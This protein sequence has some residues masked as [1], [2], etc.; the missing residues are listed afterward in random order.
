MPNVLAHNYVAHRVMRVATP[1]LALGSVLPDFAGMYRDYQGKRVDLRLF[2][3]G[4]LGW[5][6]HLHRRTDEV[7]D[8][9]PEKTRA[10]ADLAAH[11]RAYGIKPGAARLSAHL[12]ADIMLD[13]ALIDQHEPRGA[14]AALTEYILDGETELHSGKFTPDFTQFVEG[15][16]E[17]S[18]PTYYSEP[19]KLARIT[20]RR[21]A[22]RART[23]KARADRTIG[24]DQLPA[25]TEVID[26]QADRVRRLG[27]SALTRTILILEQQTDAGVP[28]S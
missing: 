21:L 9:Q 7:F 13:G 1:N 17:E 5:G 27:L 24:R 6:I 15:Y 28:V 12:L 8:A 23:A 4:M 14:F 10:T 11:L 18:V 22:K 19:E 2:R 26:I 20:A 3:E 16:F 25:L